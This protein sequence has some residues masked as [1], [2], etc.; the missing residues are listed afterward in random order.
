[1]WI[2][3]VIEHWP[4]MR[5]FK[6]EFFPEP[7]TPCRGFGEKLDVAFLIKQGRGAQDL[8]GE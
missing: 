6:R 2:R 7:F 3:R 8:R 4:G 1:M 5:S